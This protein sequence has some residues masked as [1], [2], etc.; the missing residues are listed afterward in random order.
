M[1]SPSSTPLLTPSTLLRLAEIRAEISSRLSPI[2]IG[3]PS[4]AFDELMDQISHLQLSFEL[5][6][7][8][9]SGYVDT[10]SGP[11]DR[12]GPQAARNEHGLARRPE[13]PLV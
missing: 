11:N 7:L 8:G 9:A 2:S 12:R 6:A 1:S 3:M 13:D 5:R 4:A 10:R